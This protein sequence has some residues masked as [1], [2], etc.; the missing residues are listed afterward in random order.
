MDESDDN[1]SY[2]PTSKRT[3]RYYEK[4]IRKNTLKVLKR[5]NKLIQRMKY[6]Q[7]PTVKDALEFIDRASK[8]YHQKYIKID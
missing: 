7:Y 5:N 6:N 4:E 1:G 3:I 2:V 8:K